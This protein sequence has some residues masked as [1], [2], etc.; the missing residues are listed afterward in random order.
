MIRRPPRSTLFPYTTLFR[1]V[2][3]ALAPEQA[4]AR[5]L[6]A[7]VV[8]GERDFER[9]VD[10]L[11]AG[12]AEEHM[13]EVAGRE[14]RNAARELERLRVRELE[15]RRIVE[16]GGLLLDRRHDRIAVV[17]RVAAPH[18]GRAVDHLAALGR[19]GIFLLFWGGAAGGTRA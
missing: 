2:I 16:L 1:S 17:A 19:G 6:A 12:I 8:I 14:R 11:G 5:G 13:V 15:C 18:P 9:G 4:R 10:R 3:A 7:H